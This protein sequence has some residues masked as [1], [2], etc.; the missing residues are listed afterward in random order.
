MRSIHRPLG[1][2]LAAAFAAGL[3]ACGGAESESSGGGG[4]SGQLSSVPGFDGKTIRLGHIATLS[5]PAAVLGEPAAKGLKTYF[6]AVNAKGGIAGK[7]KVELVQQDNQYDTNVSVQRF[8]QIKGDVVMFA[9]VF[10]TPGSLAVLPLLESA[11]MTAAPASFDAFWV[12]EPNL[13]PIAAPYQ[14]QAINAMDYYLTD[15]GG[16]KSDTI[17]S[18]YQDNVYGEAGQE[19]LEYAAQKLGFKIAEVQRFDGGTRDVTGQLQQLRSANC[20]AVWL[21]AVPSDAGTILGT[22]AKQRMQVQWIGQGPV[23]VDELGKSPLG[24][25]LEQ[26]L[27]VAAEGPEWGDESVAGMKQMLSD[28]EQFAKGQQPDSYYLF[29]Y[30]QA[31]AVTALLEKAVE[32]GDLS[33]EG[34]L[35]ANEQLGTVEFGGLLGDYAY[36]P[37]A[38]RNPPRVT[39]I[40]KPNA[41][42]PFGLEALKVNF[43]SD[44]AKSFEFKEYKN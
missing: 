26:A 30:V 16:S 7:Y 4:G 25:Y 14:I 40:F 41:K 15:G 1:L 8:N 10:G 39:T 24:P 37:A 34:I 3:T 35:K 32:L 42:K 27:I 44:A 22:A 33:K 11:K 5:G 17:C 12:R 9:Q 6:D 18:M 23:W 13:I 28:T 19:G 38:E 36:G 31:K 29:G 43:T 20:D 21:G 2:L